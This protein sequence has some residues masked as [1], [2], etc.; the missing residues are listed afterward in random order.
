MRTGGAGATPRG[1]KERMLRLPY[2]DEPVMI[3]TQKADI[4]LEQCISFAFQSVPRLDGAKGE[5]NKWTGYF[6]S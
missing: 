4:P 2:N 1:A 5:F 3:G 6:L